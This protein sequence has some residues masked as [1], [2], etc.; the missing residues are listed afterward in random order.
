MS[1]QSPIGKTLRLIAADSII[2]SILMIVIGIV[3][4]TMP[5]ASG[6][7][8]CLIVGWILVA[9]GVVSIA[10]FIIYGRVLA[11]VSLVFGVILLL[12]GAF[13]LSN[14]GIVLSMITIIFGALVVLDAARSLSDGI[15]C[16][17]AGVPGGIPLIVVS[18]LLMILG[19]AV[20][21]GPFDT[22][23]VF[24]GWLLL[25][26]GIIDLVMIAA[27]GRR[28]KKAKQILNDMDDDVID[29]GEQ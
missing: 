15:M 12:C 2:V 3:F 4:I 29:L 10:G 21:F 22:V 1:D 19:I 5:I 9:M 14:P 28:I 23:V 8:L 13:C 6:V 16:Q 27:F 24:L 20:I 26:D 7:T 18:V 25:A 17:R 11:G